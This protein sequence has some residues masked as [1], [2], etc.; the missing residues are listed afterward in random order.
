M[1]PMPAPWDYLIITASNEAQAVAYRSQIELRRSIGQLTRVRHVLVVTDLEGRRIGSGGSTIECLRQV[2]SQER[3]VYPSDTAEEILT[4]LRILI[5]HAGGDS[6]RLPAYSPCGKIFVPLPSESYSAL[7]A[8]IFDRLVPQFFAL[9]KGG[10][11]QVV[12][13]AGDALIDIDVSTVRF[14]QPGIT[15]LGAYANPEEASRHGVFCP[16]GNGS[17]RLYLQ[18]PNAADQAAMRAMDRLGQTVLD[19]GVMSL[20]AKAAVQLLSLF[21]RLEESA[22]RLEWKPDMKDVTLEHGIDIYREICCALGSEANLSHYSREV[23]RNGSKID[24]KTL[25]GFFAVLGPVQL[26]LQLLEK[27]S[28]LHFGSTRQLISSGIALLTKDLGKIPET[29]ALTINNQLEPKGMIDGA[30]SWIEGCRLSAPLCLT[31]W[32]VLTGID[33]V[34][35]LSLSSGMCIDVSAGLDRTGAAVRFVRCYGVDDSFKHTSD[36]GATFCGRPLERWMRE[37]GAHSSDLWSDSILETERTLW[38]AR[39]F[40][41][42]PVTPDADPEPYRPWLWFFDVKRSTAEEKKAFLAADR[43]SAA[44]VAALVDQSAFHSRRTATRAAGISQSLD[45]LFRPDSPFSSHDLAFALQ[46]SKRRGRMVARVLTLAHSHFTPDPS[47]IDSARADF[48]FCRIAHCL[49]SAI[50]E[51]AGNDTVGLM[52]LI[53][54]SRA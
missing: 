21:C 17:V 3:G 44:E 34:H 52:T 16:G 9:P 32:N 15:A 19:L 20:D 31:G 13:T 8:T 28:F 43:Y 22:P 49:G 2:I 48:H 50:E 35:P 14:D 4:R 6:R 45:K 41:A 47:P 46:R 10:A 26:N 29:T 30:N 38:N 51:M 27:S 24:E 12:V 1:K 5:L 53:P 36:L 39:V 25:N 54:E 7:G 40:P 11:G 33:V 23:R 18:K 42:E 37:V